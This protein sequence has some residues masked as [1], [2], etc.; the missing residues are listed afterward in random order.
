MWVIFQQYQTKVKVTLR[1]R[2]SKDDIND[3]VSAP[4]LKTVED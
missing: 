4:H 1:G 3:F 2:S